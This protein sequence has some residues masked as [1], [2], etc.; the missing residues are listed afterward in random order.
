MNQVDVLST[1]DSVV[2]GQIAT[3]SVVSWILITSSL[4]PAIV[5]IV[6]SS[7]YSVSCVRS[8]YFD[9]SIVVNLFLVQSATFHPVEN[10]RNEFPEPCGM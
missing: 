3:A 10:W 8:V 7:R 9:V 6:H 4:I 1:E 2:I 5:G